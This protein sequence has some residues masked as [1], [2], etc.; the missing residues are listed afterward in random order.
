MMYLADELA[1]R[2]TKI[3]MGAKDL[4]SGRKISSGVGVARWARDYVLARAY[5]PAKL[6]EGMQLRICL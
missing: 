2:Q 4:D 3:N 1:Y 6:G 5:P